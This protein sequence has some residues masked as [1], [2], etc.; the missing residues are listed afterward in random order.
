MGDISQLL[1]TVQSKGGEDM[2]K[3]IAAGVYTVRDM[4]QQFD[5]MSGMGMGNILKM[6]PGM[7][8]EMLGPLAESTGSEK[9]KHYICAL[10]SMREIELDSDGKIFY[11]EPWRMKRVALGAGITVS[12]IDELLM[13]FTNVFLVD[14]DGEDG[15]DYGWKQGVDQDDG[16]REK[17]E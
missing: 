12:E 8:A 14:A 6:I 3:K 7:S 4:R 10:D 13:Q 17:E 1:E 15:Q 16:G 11:Q 5:M 2:M 9:I